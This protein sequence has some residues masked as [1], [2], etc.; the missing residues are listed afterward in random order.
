MRSP[1]LEQSALMLRALPYVAEEDC[2]ALKGG[3]A[4]NFFVRD[5]PRL[6]VDIDLTYLPIEPRDETLTKIGQALDRIK[7]RV[8]KGV[9]DV[10]VR[11]F[12]PANPEP[13]R[14]LT[15]ASSSSICNAV[16][17]S[18]MSRGVRYSRMSDAGV[19]G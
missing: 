16:P 17:P 1:F 19:M 7:S 9:P 18:A 11:D 2:F 5:M 10:A 13:T 4:I 3:T 6:S 8:L 14:M 15:A 12:V